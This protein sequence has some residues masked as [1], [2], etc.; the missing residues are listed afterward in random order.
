LKYKYDNA[1]AV[2][3]LERKSVLLSSSVPNGLNFF[4]LWKNGE[5]VSLTGTGYVDSWNQLFVYFKQF[6]LCICM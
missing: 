3:F 5:D 4:G 1:L 6:K 2:M